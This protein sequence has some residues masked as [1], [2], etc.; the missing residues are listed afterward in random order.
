MA[1][2]AAVSSLTFMRVSPPPPAA[3]VAK[4]R[5]R[6]GGCASRRGV[7]AWGR[8]S[9]RCGRTGPSA[10][11]TSCSPAH[12]RRRSRSCIIVRLRQGYHASVHHHLEADE[13]LRVG[14]GRNT[15]SINCNCFPRP[16]GSRG[17]A[18]K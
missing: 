4:L 2:A 17:L 5:V 14:L 15:C 8:A 18:S 16:T 9:W 7:G 13:G 10:S 1:W 11:A 12:P 6:G 3:L